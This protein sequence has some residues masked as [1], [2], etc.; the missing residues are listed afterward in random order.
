MHKAW[1]DMVQL[2][3][4]Y[5]MA[6]NIKNPEAERLAAEVAG[7]AGESKTEAIRVAL[8]ERKEKLLLSRGAASKRERIEAVLRNRIW[9]WPQVDPKLLG[10]PILKAEREGILGY[11][12]D[13]I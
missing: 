10:R 2:W 11:G 13:G 4:T 9:I 3:Y 6:L 7:L 12:P 1:L 5:T 8:S